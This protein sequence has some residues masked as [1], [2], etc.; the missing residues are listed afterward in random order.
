MHLVGKEIVRFHT[1]IWP[2]M[3]D[4]AGSAAAEAGLTA[5]AGWCLDGGKMCKSKGN[6]VDPGVLCEPLRRRRD[7]LLPACARCPFGADGVFTNEALL[8]NRMNCDLA[9]DLGNLLSAAPAAMAAES[10]SAG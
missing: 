9:D 3:L 4:G 6:V 7:P 10:I 5:T 8:I 2:I 1:I